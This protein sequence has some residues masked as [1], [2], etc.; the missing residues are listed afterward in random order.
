MTKRADR[1]RKKARRDRGSI[2]PKQLLDGAFALAEEV[3]I[4]NFSMP[5]LA[6]RLDV[7]ITNIYWH[8]GR[9]GALLEAMRDRS[10]A[11][12]ARST[13]YGEGD[14][15]RSALSA[16]ATNAWKTLGA[17]PVMC[18]L[19]LSRAPTTSAVAQ[20]GAEDVTKAV[21]DLVDAGL[22]KA[23]AWDTVNAVTIH[24]RGSMLLRRLYDK[25]FRSD[26]IGFPAH[27]EV[28]AS[29]ADTL[30]SVPRRRG[31]PDDRLFEFGLNCLLDDAERRISDAST[32]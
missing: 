10:V 2:T 7:G 21:A 17:N 3:G 16:Y 20:Y 31:I 5:S 15:W 26:T 32:C 12:F 6:K 24:I 25:Q 19:V 4:D 1:E 22:P 30:D 27:P 9:K 11:E 8:F 13:A 29:K 14:D 23:D 28:P 18:D